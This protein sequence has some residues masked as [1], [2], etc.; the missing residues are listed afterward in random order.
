MDEDWCCIDYYF[1]GC[2]NRLYRDFELYG[3]G[4][5]G[6][7]RG[8][9]W[10]KRKGNGYNLYGSTA[11]YTYLYAFLTKLYVLLRNVKKCG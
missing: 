11:I 2:K 10:G 6:G 8:I 1:W 5:L 3:E 7:K 9:F 4:N